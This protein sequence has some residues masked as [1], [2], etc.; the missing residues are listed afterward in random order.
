VLS[1]PGL[2]SLKVYNTLGQLVRTIVDGQKPEGHHEAVW[3]GRNET[4][5]SVAS[6]IYIYRMISG[7][8]VQ[9]KKML[10]MK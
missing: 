9:T 3:D 2:V 1:E 4:G 7:S 5:A 8:F 6:G 10:L